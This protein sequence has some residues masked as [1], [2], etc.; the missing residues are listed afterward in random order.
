MLGAIVRSSNRY[1][2]RS[3]LFGFI[4]TAYPAPLVF[5]CYCVVPKYVGVVIISVMYAPLPVGSSPCLC[6]S[7]V[8][9]SVYADT[10]MYDNYTNIQ[11][12]PKYTVLK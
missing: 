10:C 2:L 1:F 7:A 12:A 11:Y 6:S 8:Y 3:P 4:C 5:V 9:Q